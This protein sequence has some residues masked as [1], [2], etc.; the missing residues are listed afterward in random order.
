MKPRGR[1]HMHAASTATEM[2]T[3]QH[4]YKIYTGLFKVN[5]VERG[6]ACLLIGVA[7]DAS[8]G[9]LADEQAALAGRQHRLRAPRICIHAVV[10]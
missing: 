2:V 1:D 5:G 7:D 8:L 6:G 10:R 3:R 4:L 9:L